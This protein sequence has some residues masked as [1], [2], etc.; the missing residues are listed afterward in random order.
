MD[1]PLTQAPP[2]ALTIRMSSAGPHV[3]LPWV[4]RIFSNLKVWALGIYHG[5]RRP[6]LQSCGGSGFLDSGIS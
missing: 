2:A 3:V 6:H 1:G 4:H 5:L